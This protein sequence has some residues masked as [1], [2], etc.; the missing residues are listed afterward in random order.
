MTVPFS[1]R[2]IAWLAPAEI[3]LAGPLSPIT[4]T[5]T[6]LF[7]VAP[8]P[9]WPFCPAPQAMTLPSLSRARLYAEPSEI[10]A[11]SLSPLTSTGT[12]LLSLAPLPSCPFLPP[13][14]AMTLP[15]LSRARLSSWPAA[16]AVTSLRCEPGHGSGAGAQTATGTSLLFSVL[17]SPRLPPKLNGEP[18]AMT[19][20]LS[21]RATPCSRPAETAVTPLSSFTATGTSL[22]LLAPLP[23]CPSEPA[24][25]AF[26]VFG[27][28]ACAGDT[29]ASHRS[30]TTA[31]RI[32]GTARRPEE[33]AIQPP[34][35]KPISLIP[36]H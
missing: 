21:S 20:P 30:P 35:T 8:L 7:P 22:S 4:S 25:H 33:A 16:I 5:G 15:F 11:T 9:S 32:I 6:L 13:P 1:S 3:A 10:A 29:N 12:E 19:V 17:P 34:A 23:S 18:H 27:A 31:T 2:A 36:P 24:H 28:W 14:Q 26:A